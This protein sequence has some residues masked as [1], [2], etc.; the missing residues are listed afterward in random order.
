MYQFAFGK[1]TV[2][3]V[4]ETESGYGD[5]IRKSLGVARGFPWNV[6]TG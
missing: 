5:I 1:A 3:A 2:T 6:L 4:E